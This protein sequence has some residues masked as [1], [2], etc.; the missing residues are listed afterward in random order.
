M[1]GLTV[2]HRHGCGCAG[3]G[4][5]AQAVHRMKAGA[6]VLRHGAVFIPAVAARKELHPRPLRRPGNRA[7]TPCSDRQQTPPCVHPY[8]LKTPAH[9]MTGGRLVSSQFQ[10]KDGGRYLV[11]THLAD[12]R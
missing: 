7:H 9:A 3:A 5:P 11:A 8:M 2:R 6:S 12:A 4:Q 1:G 10:L